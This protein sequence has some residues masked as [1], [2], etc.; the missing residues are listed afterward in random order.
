MVEADSQ[1]E[2]FFAIMDH[3]SKLAYALLVEPGSGGDDVAAYRLGKQSH[4]SYRTVVL[5]QLTRWLGR[6]PGDP[7]VGL[8]VP[9]S[10]S[11]ALASRVAL[12]AVWP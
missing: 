4:A 6:G 8:C 9:K 3:L 11:M 2:I 10:S 7:S 12:P 5:D 1:Q